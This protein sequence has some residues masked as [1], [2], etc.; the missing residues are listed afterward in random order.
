[1]VKRKY[2]VLTSGGDAPGMNAAVRAVVRTGLHFGC[3]V[4]A[5][6]N[7]FKG[8][9]ASDFRTLTARDVGGIIQQGG[10]ILGSA[11]CPEFAADG[12]VEKAGEILAANGVHGL[13]VIGGNGSQTGAAALANTGFPVVGIA[14]TIDNDLCGTDVSIGVDTA[15][16]VSLEAIDRI[17]VTASSHH[18]AFLVEVMGRHCGHLA[19]AAGIAGGAEAIVMPES[20]MEPETLARCFR[21][22]YDRGKA[23]AIGVIAEG[24]VFNAHKL[25]AY[26]RTHQQRLGFDLRVITLGH[27]QRGGA[28]GAFDRLLATRLGV[29]AVECLHQE[30]KGVLVGWQQG[31]VVSSPYALVAGKIKGIDQSL[32]RMVDLLAA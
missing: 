2:A 27:V 18:L 32:I 7:G 15:L 24:A 10:T 6:Q 23:H 5:V 22:A 8:L 16:N 3:E 25:S 26:F 14:S 29:A 19:L 11:R 13:I 28:P 12:G 31:Q 9:L 4:M 1:M 20:E 21:E 17:K 30:L